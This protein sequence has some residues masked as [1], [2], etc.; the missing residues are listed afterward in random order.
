M[1]VEELTALAFLTGES[2]NANSVMENARTLRGDNAISYEL[3]LPALAPDDYLL[4]RA[5]PKLVY[6]L[7]CRGIKLPASGGVF[8]SI[9]T[10]TGLYCVDAGPAVEAMARARGLTLAELVR[11][12]GAEGEGDPPLLGE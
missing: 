1:I 10:Q 8:L 5:L 7:D 12:Y 9:F 2:A 6:F 3:V 4:T 11:R